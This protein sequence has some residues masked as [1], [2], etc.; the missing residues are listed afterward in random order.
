MGLVS[1]AE[2]LQTTSVIY[3]CHPSFARTP[4][5]SVTTR[6]CLGRTSQSSSRRATHTP[7]RNILFHTY[8]PLPYQLR[9]NAQNEYKHSFYIPAAAAEG[10]DS[11]LAEQHAHQVKDYRHVYIYLYIYIYIYI[12][13]YMY[14]HTHIYIYIYIYIYIHVNLYLHTH[15]Y[16]YIYIYICTYIYMYS[17][18][19]IYLY[20]YPYIYIYISKYLYLPI[21]LYIY[22]YLYLY[23]HIHIHIYTC[24]D[25]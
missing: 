20:L 21:Y 5:T 6:H 1:E 4:T 19:S 25:R 7:A 11:A 13:T 16:I 3:L 2:C 18:L 10:V 8:I 14:I 24:V 9:A 17:Y 23:L 12:Y 22:L 15:I